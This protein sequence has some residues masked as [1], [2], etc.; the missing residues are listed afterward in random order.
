MAAEAEAAE[1]EAAEAEAAEAEAAIAETEAAEAEAAEAEAAEA[2]AEIVPAPEP[3]I[4]PLGVI[5]RKQAA[6]PVRRTR[7]RYQY[8]K[9][10]QLEVL[11][12]PQKQSRRRRRRQLVL[13]EETGQVVSK[14]K[15]KR[16]ADSNEW[17][18][19]DY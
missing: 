1:A 16:D 14:R 8:V 13:D 5:Q 17:S 12:E 10:E 15:H 2:E 9:D 19:Q 11:Q 18:D 6:E 7:P 4:K 3:E